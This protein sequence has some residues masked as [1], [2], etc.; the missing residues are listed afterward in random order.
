MTVEITKSGTRGSG[1]L[2]M[3]PWALKLFHLVNLGGFRLGGRWMKVQGRTLLLLTTVGAKTG[4]RRRTTLGFFPD[5]TGSGGGDT[6]LVVASKAG[7]ATHPAWYINMAKNPDKVWAEIGTD[8]GRVRK[9]KPESLKGEERERAWQEV[10]RL[11]PGYAKYQEQ[12]D[13][14]IPIVRLRATGE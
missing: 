8:Q 9:V 6:W 10:V 11:S 3:P 5:S 12:T 2:N 7:T 1:F 13:R 4:Q 14:V